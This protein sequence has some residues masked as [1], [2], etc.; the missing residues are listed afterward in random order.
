MP[1]STSP[2]PGSHEAPGV[3]PWPGRPHPLGATWD[4]EGTNFALYAAGAEAVDVCLFDT[5]GVET[6]LSLEESTYHV[7]HGYLPQVH[8]GQRYGFRVDGPFDPANGSRWNPSKLLADPYARA[9]DGELVID[10]RLAPGSDAVYGFPQG[11]DDLVQDH[12][13][14][15]PYVPKSVVVHDAFPWGDD[16]RPQTPWADTVIYELHVKG[17]TKLHPGIPEN[18]RGTYAG[19]GHPESVDY[20]KRL[21]ITAVELLPVHQFVSEPYVQSRGLTNY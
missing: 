12:R 2:G 14:S 21:G 17:F 11:R 3:A 16:H 8:P 19:L 1:A 13:D 4:G 10:E 5:D 20:L 18:L 7:W 6:R 15:A 9:F